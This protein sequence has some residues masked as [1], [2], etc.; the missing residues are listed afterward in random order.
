MMG[1]I[2]LCYR[3]FP[4]HHVSLFPCEFLVHGP[5]L[6]MGR[7]KCRG[8][9]KKEKTKSRGRM[10][11]LKL[12]RVLGEFEATTRNNI[13]LN[14]SDLAR[15]VGLHPSRIS[16]LLRN[17]MASENQLPA[18]Q[19]H[20]N[21]SGFNRARKK[22][23]KERRCIVKHAAL[24]RKRGED[25]TLRPACRNQE[26]IREKLPSHLRPRNVCTV[27]RDLKESGV[28]RCATVPTPCLG[29][30]WKRAR[31]RYA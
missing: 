3:A 9:R 20:T 7:P 26:E 11:D 12:G 21:L 17:H 10:T 28:R 14:Q 1:K 6:Q 22:L 16:R 15:R 4:P 18:T 24:K 25:D 2:V 13:P 31:K 30:A 8:V 29:P 27:S 5:I 19:P 23:I